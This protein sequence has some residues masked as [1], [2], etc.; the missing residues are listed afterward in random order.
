MHCRPGETGGA[1]PNA[2]LLVLTEE[3]FL[4]Q[5][6]GW[7]ALHWAASQGQSEILSLLLERDARVDA[8][9]H[10]N[11]WTALHLA[12]IRDSAACAKRLLHAG[13]KTTIQDHYG[14]TVHELL[15]AVK[16]KKKERWLQLFLKA[17]R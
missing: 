10:V 1:D 12:V 15:K 6:H 11:G 14:D 13:A 9:E 8:V 5:Q 17:K 16:G 3:E 4:I 7:S 2:F